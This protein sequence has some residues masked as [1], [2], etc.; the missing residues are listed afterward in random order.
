MNLL[1]V[2]IGGTKISAAIINSG[3]ELLRKEVRLL[4][5]ASGEAAGRIVTDLV[6]RMLEVAQGEEPVQGIGICVPG[7]ARSK[8]DTVWCPNIPGWEAFP[9]RERLLEAISARMGRGCFP[10]ERLQVESDRTCYIL[11]EIWK[12]AAAGATDAI[13]IA[14][15]TGIGAGILI[16]GRVL[17]GAGD[18]V[19]ATGWMALQEPFLPEYGEVGC[20]EY[21][22]SGNGLGANARRL[23]RER[24]DYTGVLSKKPLQEISSYDI[25]ANYDSGDSISVELIEKAI[26]LWGMASANLVSLFNPQMVVFGG[27]L[28]G[29][30]SRF[31]DRIY[32]EACRWGQ[33]VSM[34]EVKFC[35]TALKDNAALLGAASLALRHL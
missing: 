10:M 17:H 7:I 22:A 35:A 25:F 21:H 13:Y 20:F 11:G 34:K 6:C 26:T 28:F 1:G 27:G 8:N 29:P 18:V 14:V 4:G 33:P 30:A 12:G 24:K 32:A 3:G 15:G 9:L 2:D 31:I 16:D 5:G 23:L 19:G